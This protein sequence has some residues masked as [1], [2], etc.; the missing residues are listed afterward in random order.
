MDPKGCK[1][2]MV[3]VRMAPKVLQEKQV[4]ASVTEWRKSAKKWCAW[5]LSRTWALKR[6]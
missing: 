2:E 4:P 5:V 3:P 1:E 6:K